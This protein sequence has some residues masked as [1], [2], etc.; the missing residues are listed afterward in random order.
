MTDL[1]IP[2]RDSAALLEIT[3]W[4]GFRPGTFKPAD[5]P[6][7][8]VRLAGSASPPLV[9]SR[10]RRAETL[11]AM[12]ASLRER[13]SAAFE[14]AARRAARLS[15]AHGRSLDLA[16]GPLVMGVV[17]VTPDSFSDGGLYFDRGRAVARALEL[18]DSGAAIVDIG[19]E[20]TR[21]GTYGAAQ[22]VSPEEEAARVLPVI[23]AI[24]K[25]SPA[26]LSI[27]TRR[28]SVARAAIEAG[29]DLVND[30]T[31][32]RFDPAMA[33]TVAAAG[34]A[35]ILMHMRGLDP[36]T[37]QSD[38]T[39]S[40]LLADVAAQLAAA[41]TRAEAAGVRGDA[42]AVDP[43]LGF[44]KSPE[45]NLVLLRHLGALRS[46]GFP[47]VIGASRKAFVRR[48]SGVADDSPAGDR[49]P[50]SLACAE[51]AAA[52]GAAIV[53]VHDAAETVRFFSMR[54]AIVT[55]AAAPRPPRADSGSLTPA[56]A[57]AS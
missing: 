4:D 36:R 32:F 8:V 52:G 38:T 16:S 33:E 44:G 35:A 15:L 18:F 10:G 49:L 19:G 25:Q 26:P 5:F 22:E 12:P 1:V 9:I 43:G 17:N 3:G 40:H 57:A 41:A 21:P 42:I 51:A 39:Y 27:D 30:V 47:L 46:L 45:G 50:G 53:R 56:G 2:A 20:S 34:A 37:M 11:K 7:D 14:K 6:V 31:A 48:F 54:R 29:A 55:P 24:R 28:A 13:A 23:E